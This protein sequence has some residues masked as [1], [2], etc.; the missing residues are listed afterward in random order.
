[1]DKSST[2]DHQYAEHQQRRCQQ[3]QLSL[4]PLCAF[5]LSICLGP[6]FA[7]F[8]QTTNYDFN[9][10]VSN[11]VYTLAVQQDGKIVIAAP[12]FPVRLDDFRTLLKAVEHLPRYCA[13]PGC[14]M[15][16]RVE[17]TADKCSLHDRRGLVE[18]TA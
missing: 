11:F 6:A 5:Y 1:M 7:A 3:Y 14:Q 15:A 2:G 9:T 17:D 18:R 8:G 13:Q 16:L 4:I 10:Q 12:R